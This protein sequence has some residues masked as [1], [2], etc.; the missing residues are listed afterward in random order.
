M[1]AWL[2]PRVN[3]DH[4]TEVVEVINSY[5]KPEDFHSLK[6]LNAS[7]VH[8]KQIISCFTA[9][10][11]SKGFQIEVEFISNPFGKVIKYYLVRKVITA[12]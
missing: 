1:N 4:S 3:V 7:F 2:M 6:H 5:F 10:R 9:F 8:Q 12:Y 11:F